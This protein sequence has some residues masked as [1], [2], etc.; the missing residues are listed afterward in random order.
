[1]PKKR[2]IKNPYQNTGETDKPLVKTMNTL[3]NRKQQIE[4]AVNGKE[5]EPGTRR[6]YKHGGQ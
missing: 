2:D 1:M 6:Y 5:H 4:D 3:K